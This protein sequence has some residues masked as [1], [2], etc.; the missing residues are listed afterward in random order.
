[1][2]NR[3][4]KD[5][6]ITYSGGSP[7]VP[8]RPAYCTTQLDYPSTRTASMNSSDIIS[9]SIVGTTV[10]DQNGNAMNGDLYVTQNGKTTIGLGGV[11]STG[12][13]G[14]A[15]GFA[16]QTIQP[17]QTKKCYPAQPY[18]P[19]TPP[20]VS[21]NYL[22][23]WNAGGTSEDVISANS[24]GYIVFNAC[25][26]PVGLVVGL[27]SSSV[28]RN[29]TS[30]LACQHAF[31]FYNRAAYGDPHDIWMVARIKLPSG[32]TVD[33]E[34]DAVS[35]ASWT[36]SET[37]DYAIQR[38]GGVVYFMVNGS[39]FRLDG[40]PDIPLSTDEVYMDVSMLVAPM[41]VQNPVIDE[42]EFGA[43]SANSA[44]IGQYGQSLFPVFDAAMADVDNFIL[45]T[46]E[47]FGS[48]AGNRA[49]I[50]GNYTAI[51]ANVPAA[52]TVMGVEQDQ[53]V[54][55]YSP[56]IAVV[57]MYG[58][59]QNWWEDN[60][61]AG[62]NAI[63]SFIGG[64]YAFNFT[65]FTARQ[66]NAIF[67]SSTVAMDAAMSAG[68]THG[69]IIAAFEPLTVR[70]YLDDG[71]GDPSLYIMNTY[72]YLFDVFSVVCDAYAELRG[73][74]EVGFDATLVEVTDNAPGGVQWMMGELSAGFT[75]DG[76]TITIADI[77]SM[78]MLADS[79]PP[80]MNDLERIQY[81]MNAAT[82]AITTY[83]NFGFTGFQRL[84]NDTYA[85]GNDGIYLLRPGDDNGAVSPGHIDFGQTDFGTAQR[86]NLD[87]LYLG[88]SSA[89]EVYARITDD[90]GGNHYYKVS[91]SQPTA[92][93][94][95]GRGT[96]ARRYGLRLDIAD[97]TD[98]ELDKIEFSVCVSSRRRM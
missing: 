87:S 16:A 83:R 62:Q 59:Q 22:Y 31:Y 88:M 52:F 47:A 50:G 74:L 7:G 13:S 91:Q 82:G 65:E 51:I 1:M 75:L 24:D 61:L 77:E 11:N 25:A 19:P 97:I 45:S 54:A 71:F 68:L 63:M 3:L 66:T 55:E 26:S 6:V 38:V 28:D 15:A 96:L 29:D 32:A 80:E 58:R 5:A 78:L 95:A 64:D 12:G 89:G 37:N 33:Y 41:Y 94:I 43:I 39:I 67:I 86:K 20:S 72:L 30:P 27:T 76:S 60:Y 35:M 69:Y 84:G 17:A 81:A 4:T 46:I 44:S 53:I 73:T 21:V 14:G 56:D 70:G 40:S 49:I 36:H 18:I 93:V 10:W 9:F 92:R 90:N 85:I 34:F 48:E 42:G 2:P 8:Y 23:G 57:S 79:I 98:F